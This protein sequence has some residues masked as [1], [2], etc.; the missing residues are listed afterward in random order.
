M[1]TKIVNNIPYINKES[2]LGM[3]EGIR[4]AILKNKTDKEIF[5]ELVKE[6]DDTL[7]ERIKDLPLSVQIDL[8]TDIFET[9]QTRVT[10]MEKIAN[11]EKAKES[12]HLKRI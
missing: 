1:K 11:I 10:V 8:L 3:I 7:W 9:L 12:I 6:A 2:A 5:E 4:K